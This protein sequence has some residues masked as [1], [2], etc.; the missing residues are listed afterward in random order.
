M[1]S[2]ATVY[3]TTDSMEEAERVATGLLERRL[4]ACVNIIPGATSMYRWEDEI[5]KEQ[6][7]VMIA[8]TQMR[9]VRECVNAVKEL[10]SYEVPCVTAMP[11]L[12]L[13]P[14]FGNWVI[15]ETMPKPE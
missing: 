15:S 14:A 3:M 13:N 4:V 2:L 10:H 12:K 5:K 7:V 11:V 8:K 6:E 9:M 1:S